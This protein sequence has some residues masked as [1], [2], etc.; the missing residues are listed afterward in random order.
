MRPARRG[1]AADSRPA[2]RR[3]AS[4]C[5]RR[6]RQT[7]GSGGAAVASN[8]RGAA[9]TA[10]APESPVCA[11]RAGC[12]GGIGPCADALAA[13][14]ALAGGRLDPLVAE[15][16]VK[17]L[18][19]ADPGSHVLNFAL[20]NQFAQQGRWAEAQQEYF[21][22][23][24]AEPDTPDFAYNLAVS[25]DHLRQPRLAREHYQR[26]VALAQKRGASFDVAAAR[27]RLAQLAQ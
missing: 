5:A 18:L 24:A 2:G 17:S 23:L 19:A 6:R 27:A 10:V 1:G 13:L 7:A 26:A 16:R 21:K 22:D 4:A 25:L 3:R 15:S 20:G 12:P 11:A 9:G 8:A 14:I